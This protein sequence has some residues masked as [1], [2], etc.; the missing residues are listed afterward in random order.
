MTALAVW[1]VAMT[2]IT[3]LALAA[4]RRWADR[5]RPTVLAGAWF[6]L[7]LAWLVPFRPAL[8]G[9]TDGADGSAA[10]Q[11]AAGGTTLLRVPGIGWTRPD[12]A[13]VATPGVDAARWAVVALLAVWAVGAVVEIVRAVLAHH[14]LR[15]HVDRWATEVDADLVRALLGGSAGDGR[16][17]PRV[18]V[19]PVGVSMVVGVRSPRIVLPMI[20]TD[21]D[22][23]LRHERA[24]LRRH[25]PAQRLVLALVRAV[26][27]W[28]PVVRRAVAAAVRS[29]EVAC[30]AT[31]TQH[32]GPSGRV[33]YARA[34]LTAL[35]S[36]PVPGRVLVPALTEGTDVARRITTLFAEGRRH[37]GVALL[38][39]GAA[40]VLG[41]GIPVAASADDGT[42]PAGCEPGTVVSEDGAQACELVDDPAVAA[43]E[44]WASESTVS[45]EPGTAAASQDATTAE[46]TV[47]ERAAAAEAVENR[48]SIT[49]TESS[50]GEDT[51]LVQDLS[52][53]AAQGV[54]VDA[55]G[56]PRYLGEPLKALVLDRGDE[57]LSLVW[58]DAGSVYLAVE[59]D[60][61]RVLTDEE[62]TA[63]F[64]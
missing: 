44:G 60:T 51:T 62:V 35:P 58:N 20:D 10:A 34:L 63:L 5:L 28:N 8:L 40:L 64:G 57:V 1:L 2:A 23:V 32:L 18:V 19:A 22:L 30:D 16:R 9:G 11:G 14:R 54:T 46:R 4:D 27:W 29:S 53:Y 39:L 56:T 42:T 59:G 48:E 15:T 6:V 43:P 26:H 3:G 21:V 24:H 61:L 33:R 55:D 52:A 7:L 38:T 37:R 25:D 50:E 31:A 17:L 49:I 45:E 41:V 12:P 36:A 47:A 13:A